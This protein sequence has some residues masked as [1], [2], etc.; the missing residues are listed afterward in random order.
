MYTWDD[1]QVTL[2]LQSLK[3]LDLSKLN[4]GPFFYPIKHNKFTPYL[5]NSRSLEVL[6]LSKQDL[7]PVTHI[8]LFLTLHLSK[9]GRLYTLVSQ[10][11]NYHTWLSPCH[12]WP[13]WTSERETDKNFCYPVMFVKSV[14]GTF[15]SWPVM[16]G[17]ST[18]I[19]SKVLC[20][21]KNWNGW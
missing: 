15:V 14:F 16:S 6:Y 3:V 12:T 18:S 5:L 19:R 9:S 11:C 7:G 1:L 17:L 20:M 13:Y 4:R 2:E 8:S 10:A 21:H